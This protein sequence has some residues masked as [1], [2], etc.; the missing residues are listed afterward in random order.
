MTYGDV[1]T[2]IA[3]AVVTLCCVLVLM[4]VLSVIF[5]SLG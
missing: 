2:L 3:D 1:S 5:Q 4:L